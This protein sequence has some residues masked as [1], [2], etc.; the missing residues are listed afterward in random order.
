MR[1][2]GSSALCLTYTSSAERMPQSW[3]EFS[4]APPCSWGS[5]HGVESRPSQKRQHS[6]SAQA[7]LNVNGPG[8]LMWPVLGTEKCSPHGVR[9][10]LALL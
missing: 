7:Q 1:Q 10:T 2:Q 3:G 4:P 8:A 5:G 9:G 6:Q